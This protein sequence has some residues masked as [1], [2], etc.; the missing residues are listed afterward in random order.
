MT[1]TKEQQE[2]VILVAVA[3][4][5]LGEARSSLEELELLAKT[6]GAQTAGYILQPLDAPVPATYLGSGKIKELKDLIDLTQADGI[7]CDD[8]LTPVQIRNLTEDLEV[9]VMDRT[10]LILDIFAFQA[11]TAEGKVQVEL[12]Q[13][14]YL[15]SHLAGYGTSLSRLGGGIGTRGPGEKKLEMDR[16]AIRRRITSLKRELA[17]IERHRELLREKR[18]RSERKTAAIV[19]YTN[20]GKST[21]LNVL[22]N[23]GV[24]QEDKLFATLDPTTRVLELEQGQKM[25][26]T[27]TVGFINKLPHQL[28]ESF[29][30]T[31]EEA[32]SADYLIHVVD[33]SSPEAE[34]QMQVVYETL[35]GLGV[36]TKRTLTIFNKTDQA[37]NYASL[38]DPRAQETVYASLKKGEGVEEIRLALSKFLSE[39]QIRISRIF[40]YGRAGVVNR[41]RDEGT[42]LSESYEEDG[43]H[44]E[45]FVSRELYGRLE[46]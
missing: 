40:P 16:R 3:A 25:L 36:G 44:I 45:A 46:K 42:L 13:E 37:E 41:V 2:K 23:A 24:L 43:I 29:H 19:G 11:S 34:K 5:D 28:V 27:D 7:I 14:Q 4:G 9:K 35:D 12:A 20:A 31:L 17:Q 21:L 6:A 8:E 1:E 30:S 32:C 39:D 18:K 38:R 10:L 22:T 33:A 26:L 15:A